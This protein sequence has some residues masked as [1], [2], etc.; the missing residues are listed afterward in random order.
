MT[1]FIRHYTP[2][3]WYWLITDTGQIWSSKEGNYVEG[4]PADRVSVL[5]T[6]EQLQWELKNAGLMKTRLYKTDIWARATDDEISV[7]S[8]TIDTA[9]L[10]M[11][12]MWKDSLCFDVTLPEFAEIKVPM[13]AAFGHDRA[14]ILLAPTE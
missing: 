12:M 10:R 2:N 8:A 11:Q 13:A 6:N 5:K 1:D 14:D 7:I 9:S 3:D 4:Y